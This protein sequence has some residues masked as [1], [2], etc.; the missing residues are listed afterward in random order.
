VGAREDADHPAQKPAT[1][2]QSVIS[3]AVI[4]VLVGGCNR[5]VDMRL[6]NHG[7]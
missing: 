4:N 3:S 5:P 6:I 2:L 7:E 1:L